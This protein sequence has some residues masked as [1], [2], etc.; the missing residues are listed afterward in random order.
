MTASGGSEALARVAEEQF[1]LIF[2]DLAMPGMSGARTF[3]VGADDYVTKPVNL[4]ELAVRLERA[5]ERRATLCAERADA[6]SHRRVRGAHRGAPLEVGPL[7]VARQRALRQRCGGTLPRRVPLGARWGRRAD[8]APPR[9][10]AAC[11]PLCDSLNHTRP[12]FAGF[13]GIVLNWQ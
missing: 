11:L 5:I 7:A 10:A 9:A 13:A 8:Y 2:L 3:K 4:D 6:R 12:C 1:D